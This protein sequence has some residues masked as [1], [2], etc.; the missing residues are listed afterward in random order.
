LPGCHPERIR[1]AIEVGAAGHSTLIA[2]WAR[3]LQK[4]GLDPAVA[5]P[6]RQVGD[7]ELR[8]STERIKP[9]LNVAQPVLSRLENAFDGQRACILIAGA[10]GISVMRRAPPEDERSLNMLGLSVG[11]DWS[12]HREGTNAIGT[13]LIDGF[14]LMVRSEDHFYERDTEIG[15]MVAPIFDHN[16]RIAGALDVTVYGRAAERNC[17]KLGLTLVAD[18]ARQIEINHFHDVFSEQRIVSLR[19]EFRSG[20]SLIAVDGDDI[21]VGATRLARLALDIS[22]TEIRN[23][24]P[25][26]DLLEGED[27]DLASAER[28]VLRRTLVRSSGNVSRAA[29]MLHISRA[30]MKRKLNEH[31]VR[32]PGKRV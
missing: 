12:E 27:D 28:K 1:T 5:P 17:T 2:S 23:G 4:Y 7:S 18:A 3:C 21:I 24:T 14:P 31:G 8:V 29:Q 11:F 9:L 15:C 16:A 26:S 32:R 6:R 30:T 10:D 19:D 13:A 20:S 25:A 22:D